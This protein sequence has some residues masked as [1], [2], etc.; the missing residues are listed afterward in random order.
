MTTLCLHENP[1][2]RENKVVA[3]RSLI[4]G[5]EYETD[6]HFE[7]VKNHDMACSVCQVQRSDVVMVPG[8]RTCPG[9]WVLEYE[10]MIM[11]ARASL[12]A[13]S[14]GSDF[15]CVSI[16]FDTVPGGGNEN[17]GANIYLTEI[18]CNSLPCP[19]YEAETELSCVVCSK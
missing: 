3:R 15:I 2:R 13:E 8:R 10:G 7:E 14:N 17:T 19:P 16:A 4:R 1:Q 9:G 6:G 12:S 5:V 11:G 18:E